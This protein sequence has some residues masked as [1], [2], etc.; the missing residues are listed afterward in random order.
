MIERVFELPGFLIIG[1]FALAG[2]LISVIFAPV[3]DKSRVVVGIEAVI[4]AIVGG[5]LAR[6]FI[7]ILLGLAKNSAAAGFALG[8]GFF[9]IPGIIDTIIA[10]GAVIFS[11]APF[12]GS[13]VFSTPSNL[14]IYATVVG[15]GT[16]MMGGVYS[17]Y[18]WKGLG[19]LAFP[20]DVTWALAGNTSGCLMH[21]INLIWREHSDET[22]DNAHRYA[23]GFGLRYH[24]R[25]AFTQGAV[26]SNL[27]E[28][29]AKPLYNHE[30]THVWQNRGFGPVYT[31]TYVGWVVVWLVPAMIA[32]VI[33]KGIGGLF[34]GPNNWCYFNC[35][36]ETWAYSVQG[37][38][39]TDIDGQDPDDKKMIWPAKFVLAWS[40]PFFM[41][42]AGLMVLVVFSVWG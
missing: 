14:L 27:E 37:S 23:M 11:G 42:V 1:G 26:M 25:Y 39:R 41:V 16:G 6:G 38:N 29:K 8:W 20:L 15:A 30:K 2:F 22:R 21:F 17:I 34:S 13:I 18:D 35:P 4:L 32:G 5:I 7:S 40:V 19:W 9:L 24:P 31:L 36:W 3:K 28:P 33:V 10:T 12:L